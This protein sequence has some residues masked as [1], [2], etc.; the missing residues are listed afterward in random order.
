MASAA[1]VHYWRVITYEVKL[2]YLGT[3]NFNKLHFKTLYNIII[4][5]HRKEDDNIIYR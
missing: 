2:A 4:I 3:I 1:N 5:I